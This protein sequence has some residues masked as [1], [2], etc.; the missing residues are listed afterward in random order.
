MKKL[1]S[2]LLI[3]LLCLPY[4]NALAEQGDVIYSYTLKYNGKDYKLKNDVLKDSYYG[5]VFFP[6]L[7]ILQI[8]DPETKQ[9]MKIE[10]EP[11]PA[12]PNN[13]Y[14]DASYYI[15]FKEQIFKFVGRDSSIEVYDKTGTV[16]QSKEISIQ[17]TKIEDAENPMLYVPKEFFEQALG[18][19]TY[20][21]IESSNSEKLKLV[22]QSSDYKADIQE[23]N[24]VIIMKVNDPW[25]YVNE[26]VKRIDN[27]AYSTPVVKNGA[28]LLPISN[29]IKELGGNVAWDGADQRVTITL[30]DHE[31]K[32]WLNKAT[33]IVDGEEKS[34]SVSPTII[35]GRTMVPLRFV[36]D[37]LGVKLVWDKENQIIALYNGDFQF[38]PAFYDGYFKTDSKNSEVKAEENKSSQVKSTNP[39]DKNGNKIQ[40]GDRVICGFFYG[41]VQ[42]VNGGRILVY[43]DG[44][45]N[46]WVQD[47]DVDYV[48]MLAGINYKDSSWID[49]SRL[50]IE[51]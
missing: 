11:N 6:L 19:N 15:S 33:A 22:I 1:L 5:R 7:E 23:N 30:N 39:I 42:Q 26:D 35:A 36:S 12:A 49:A 46:L 27:V 51:K 41:E 24:M 8:V 25:M 29:I 48:A 16:R 47:K 2:V 13:S 21:S 45:D 10:Q 38:I 20:V 40:L 44:K 3:L 37:N 14:I 9:T 43:W 28:T 4:S 18:T 17:T 32:L 31:V 50:T 34:I